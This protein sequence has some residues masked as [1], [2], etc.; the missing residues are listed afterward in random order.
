MINNNSNNIPK[1][2]NQKLGIE[3]YTSVGKAKKREEKQELKKQT[4]RFEDV[5]KQPIPKNT[6][7]LLAVDSMLKSQLNIK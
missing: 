3:R 5:L 1:R 7:E 6:K 4:E 2:H